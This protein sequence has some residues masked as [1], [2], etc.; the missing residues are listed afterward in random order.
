MSR[1]L[2]AACCLTMAAGAQ[3]AV[4]P[5]QLGDYKKVASPP[6]AVKENQ[7]LWENTA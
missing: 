1:L 7:A 4:W 5:D 2:V 3:G 6:V